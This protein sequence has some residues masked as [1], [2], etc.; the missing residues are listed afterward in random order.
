[1]KRLAIIPTVF[2]FVAMVAACT[3]MTAPGFTPQ[4]HIFILGQC[5]PGAVL[6]YQDDNQA[7]KNGDGWVCFT[8]GPRGQIIV[9]DNN[10]PLGVELPSCSVEENCRVPE[11]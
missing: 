2:V 9:T 1:M 3:D 7:D 11:A 4:F 5:P 8:S 6:G 10:V